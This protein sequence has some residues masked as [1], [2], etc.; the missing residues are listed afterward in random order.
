MPIYEY[1]CDRCHKTFERF[2]R[3]TDEPLYHCPDCKGKVRRLISCTSFSLKGGG[4]YKDGYGPKQPDKAGQ[5][6]AGDKKEDKT[7]KAGE[8]K[9]TDSTDK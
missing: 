5:K 6:M 4:W 7:K 8:K 2:Q 3:I 1:Q 9:K